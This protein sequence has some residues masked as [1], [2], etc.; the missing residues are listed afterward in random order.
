MSEE[1]KLKREVI[2][3]VVQGINKEIV[4]L[5]EI[6]K[7]VEG[8]KRTEGNVDVEISNIGH[9]LTDFQSV[10]KN[11]N[12]LAKDIGKRSKKKRSSKSNNATKKTLLGSF[13]LSD[14]SLLSHLYSRTK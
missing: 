8:C 7:M 13:A 2:A 1:A 5:K 14:H 11:L 6:R 9:Y 3:T 4:R 12:T 10:S